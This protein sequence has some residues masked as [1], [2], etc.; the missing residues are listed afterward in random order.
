[1]EKEVISNSSSL[2]FI[3]KLNIFHL[4]K[5]V[6][7]KIIIPEVVIKEI[8][9][10]NSPENE[11]IQKEIDNKY[12]NINKIA[13]IKNFPLDEGEKTAIS[14]CL[15][16]NIGIFLSDDKKARI[17]A[18][19]WGIKVVGV[20]GILLSNFQEKKIDKKEFL[21]ILDELV[22]VGYYISPALYSETIKKLDEN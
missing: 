19:S 4:T 6:F 21:K 16:K 10:K 22:Q 5:N 2:I 13:N 3:A 12:I 8:L 20:L 1:M 7:S 11:L 14:L 18:K 15:K 17:Y 9:S